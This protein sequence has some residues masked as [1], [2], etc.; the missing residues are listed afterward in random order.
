MIF[1]ALGTWL[2]LDAHAFALPHHRT[3]PVHVHVGDACHELSVPEHQPL[4]AAVEAAGLLPGS[5]CRRGTCLSCSALVEA[6][7][8]FS[9]RVADTALC[10]EAHTRGIVL[11]CSAYACGEG[12]VLRLDQ[13]GAAWDIQYRQRFE[14]KGRGLDEV[15]QLKWDRAPHFHRLDVEQHLEQCHSNTA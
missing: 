1:L 6:G 15:V 2:A 13:D 12:L 4:L 10:A 7:A 14:R 8:P 9:L 11:L 5:D 3:W